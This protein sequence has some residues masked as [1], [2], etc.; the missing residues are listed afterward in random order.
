MATLRAALVMP[1]F[2]DHL[3]HGQRQMLPLVQS[4]LISGIYRVLQRP[5]LSIS[6]ACRVN[7][8]ETAE[9]GGKDGASGPRRPPRRGAHANA[10][11]ARAARPVAR[12]RFRLVRD[13]KPPA[14]MIMGL[15]GSTE[16]L[17]VFG[18]EW[19]GKGFVAVRGRSWKN[20]TGAGGRPGGA[21]AGAG[22]TGKRRRSNQRGDERYGGSNERHDMSGINA[23]RLSKR[24]TEEQA[25]KRGFFSLEDEKAMKLLE[26]SPQQVPTGHTIHS[27]TLS[28]ASVVGTG[29]HQDVD[30][31]APVPL[32][33]NPIRKVPVARPLWP[34]VVAPE[35]IAASRSY[36]V[37][38]LRLETVDLD[39]L[40]ASVAGI[41]GGAAFIEETALA[42]R[43][44]GQ[45]DLAT[46]NAVLMR[47]ASTLLALH[48]EGEK[49]GRLLMQRQDA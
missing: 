43:R 13:V 15:L 34:E 26:A 9:S 12:R 11:H 8:D 31:G 30:V 6:A 17:N 16:R 42:L 3:L 49:R 47:S 22:Q 20:R 45:Y 1:A 39:K 7:A 23:Q 48:E 33:W 38:D 25:A 27:T 19:R 18:P 37:D 2:K 14:E 10:K 41:S 29:K 21:R 24:R 32:V 46:R 44:V 4:P 5:S 28:A 40:K 35:A 36:A